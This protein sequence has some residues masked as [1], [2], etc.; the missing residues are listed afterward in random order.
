MI[1]K[2]ASPESIRHEISIM[3]GMK[4]NAEK[5][6]LVAIQEVKFESA[7]IEITDETGSSSS[8]YARVRS[9]F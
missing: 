6:N 5:N 4:D 9:G 1:L 7:T 2:V 8:P 3:E